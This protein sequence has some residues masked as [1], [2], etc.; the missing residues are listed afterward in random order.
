MIFLPR[1]LWSKDSQLQKDKLRSIQTSPYRNKY[2]KF[3]WGKK[4]NI[5]VSNNVQLLINS[6][7][8]RS[9]GDQWEYC[10][11]FGSVT[12]H[13]AWQASP[14]PT[15]KCSKL[16]RAQRLSR[17]LDQFRYI[18]IITWLRGFRGIKQNKLFIHRSTHPRRPWVSEDALNLDVISFQFFLFYSP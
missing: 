1:L 5:T 13:I 10:T 9:T 12:H 16:V 17:L 18:K 3:A 15:P 8:R 4:R 14:S 2:D 11:L 7:T 6:T